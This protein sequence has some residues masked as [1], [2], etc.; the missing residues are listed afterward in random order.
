MPSTLLRSSTP[1]HDRSRVE[2]CSCIRQSCRDA[3][4]APLKAFRFSGRFN[5]I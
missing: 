4:M 3:T 1:L 5:V 2:A